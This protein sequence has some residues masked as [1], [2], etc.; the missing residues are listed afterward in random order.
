MD[1]GD[2]VQTFHVGS[3]RLRGRLVRLSGALDSI[4]SGHNYPKPVATLLA[5]NLLIAGLLAGTLKY[6]GVFTLQAQGDGPV[7]LLVA[8][9]A[10]AGAVRGYARFDEARL[11]AAENRPPHEAVP[12]LL[13][14]GHM[15]FTVDQGPDTDRYQ[16]I[17]ALE[18]PTLA[19]CAQAY[20]RQS[21][22]IATVLKI[23]THGDAA[24][25]RGT[26]ILLQQMP[27]DTAAPHMSR[28]D[29][30]DEWRA[31][32]AILG[33]LTQAEMLDSELSSER[34]LDRLFRLE[35]LA[36]ASA[37]KLAAQCR[38]SRERVAGALRSFPREEVETMKDP[39]EDD[40]AVTC[41]F[42]KTTYR[43]TPADLGALW[44]S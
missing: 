5:E 30:E 24:N 37:K 16:G 6:D 1:F 11:S 27:G 17:V 42:C 29:E 43:F 3:G 35:G 15:A 40:V 13:G 8:D 33:S 10:S 22:Q 4:L 23:A 39:G 31:A 14:A 7:A 20:F 9:V 36:L 38:C 12:H 19:E 18:G 21:E 41:E 32:L 25:W 28:E 44:S 34:L 2:E 26:G